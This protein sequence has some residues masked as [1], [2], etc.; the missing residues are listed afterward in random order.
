MKKSSVPSDKKYLFSILIFF[1]LGAL[2]NGG[3]CLSL[4]EKSLLFFLLTESFHVFFLI[5]FCLIFRNFIH[6]KSTAL[7]N[8]SK[9]VQEL[10]IILENLPEG[11]IGISKTGAIT[12]L[13]NAA[14]RFLECSEAQALEKWMGEV[15]TLDNESGKKLKAQLKN[16]RSLKEPVYFNETLAVSRSKRKYVIGGYICPVN[17]SVVTEALL[18]FHDETEKSQN[19][20]TGKLKHRYEV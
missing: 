18:V 2:L 6:Q 5:A 7:T 11:V 9:R 12:F 16:V 10:E 4:G 15:L 1:T 20:D 17:Y 3:I 8:M 19:L 14:E 13:N